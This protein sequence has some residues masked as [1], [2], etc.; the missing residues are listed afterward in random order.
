MVTLFWRQHPL[1]AFRFA[2]GDG[3]GKGV[4]CE[5]GET[6]GGR[7]SGWSAGS[8]TQSLDFLCSA[9]CAQSCISVLLTSLSPHGGWACPFT[10]LVTP[11]DF[12]SDAWGG[13]FFP[14]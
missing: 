8:H 7:V 11:V 9:L 4:I 1:R 5:T 3:E 12:F 10:L 2:A 6:V 13:F 14:N